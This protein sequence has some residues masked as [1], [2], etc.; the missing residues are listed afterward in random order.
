[1]KFAVIGECMLELAPVNMDQYRLNYGGDVMNT[2]VH[3]A[4][5]GIDTA[6]FSALGDGYYSDWLV[7]AWQEEGIDCGEVQRLP[8]V[9]PAIYMIR[10]H[11]DGDRDFHYW[12]SASPFKL[13]SVTRN[14][15]SN[16]RKSWHSS[17]IFIIRVSR[18]RCYRSRIEAVSW[19]YWLTTATRVAAFHLIPTTD[20]GSGP[21]KTKPFSGWI[22]FTPTLTLH[23]HHWKMRH[24]SGSPT[25]SRKSS[26][27][28]IRPG[29]R[30]SP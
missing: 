23:F 16:C 1:M 18:L 21:Q 24:C 7:N 6:F 13:C 15:A 4:R 29:S 3:V 30:T 28:S 12:R 27:S 26:I 19:L 2:A 9:E 20:R 8:G 11:D 5:A 22:A 10:N 17:T 25:R 14:T